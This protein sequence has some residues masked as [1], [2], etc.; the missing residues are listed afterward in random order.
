MQSN[1]SV[2]LNILR[3]GFVA[4]CQ[5]VDDGPMDKPEIIAAMAMAS[6]A[7]GAVALRVEGIENLKAVRPHVDVPIIGIVKRDLDDSPVRITPLLEDV[8]GL[9]DAGADIIAIDASDR[10][11]PVS[12]ESLVS[13][14]HKLGRLAMAD[15]SNYVEGMHAKELGVEIIGSTLSGYTTD[16][17]PEKPDLNL[18]KKLKQ[19]GCFVMAEGRYNSP[20]LAKLAIE[21]GADSVTVGSAITRIEHI[22]SW[23]AGSVNEGRKQVMEKSA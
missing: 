19:S 3:K 9:H 10:P 14:I 11:R 4:S 15:S 8:K 13:E 5:P 6:V 21:N 20:E 22:C 7:G 23:F 2:I 17:T 1:T 18:V 16:V 12:I